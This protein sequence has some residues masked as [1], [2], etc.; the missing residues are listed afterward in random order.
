LSVT[1]VCF[2]DT[3]SP[4]WPIPSRAFVAPRGVGV[5]ARDHGVNDLPEAGRCLMKREHFTVA[6]HQAT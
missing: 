2:P 6:D 3:L 5:G 4:V 1:T